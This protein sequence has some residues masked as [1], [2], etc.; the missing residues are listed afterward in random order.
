MEISLQAMYI[1]EWLPIYKLSK[2]LTMR[3]QSQLQ[4]KLPLVWVSE[5]RHYCYRTRLFKYLGQ[6]VNI[7]LTI[8]KLQPPQPRSLGNRHAPMWLNFTIILKLNY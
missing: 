4:F 2:L 6:A 8:L 7:L 1:R 5:L 3:V